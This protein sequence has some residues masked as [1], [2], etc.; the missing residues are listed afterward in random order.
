M[1]LPLNWGIFSF[2]EILSTKQGESSLRK[3][4]VKRLYSV[5]K[6]NRFEKVTTWFWILALLCTHADFV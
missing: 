6:N 3:Y 1:Q 5:N 2:H 4:F